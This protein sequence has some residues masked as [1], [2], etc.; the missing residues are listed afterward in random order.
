MSRFLSG[1]W[2]DFPEH[3]RE[4]LVRIYGLSMYRAPFQVIEVVSSYQGEGHLITLRDSDGFM[5]VD[6]EDEIERFFL[7]DSFVHAK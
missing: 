7:E 6:G 3:D 1:D 2:V 5:V 4:M